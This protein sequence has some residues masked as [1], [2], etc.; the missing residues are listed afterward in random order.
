MVEGAL[1]MTRTVESDEAAG[2]TLVEPAKAMLRRNHSLIGEL[3]STVN[4]RADAISGS[5]SLVCL[6]PSHLIEY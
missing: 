5:K 3:E 2:F 4:D 6:S 1:L